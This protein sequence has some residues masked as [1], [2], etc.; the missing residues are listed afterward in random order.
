M[1]RLAV[2]LCLLALVSGSI[3]T[4]AFAIVD[5]GD[6]KVTRL[7]RTTETGGRFTCSA[8][9]IREAREGVAWILTAGHCAGAQYV[10]REVNGGISAAIDWRVVVTSHNYAGRLLDIALATAPDTRADQKYHSL[11]AEKFPDSGLVYIH[12][13][14]MGI[15]RV[16]VARVVGPTKAPNLL[17][18]MEVKVVPGSVLPGSSGSVVLDPQGFVVGVLWGMSVKP[19]DE[20]TGLVPGNVAYVTPIEAFHDLVKLIDAKL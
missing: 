9:Y 14:P 12:G 18:T 10:K 20:G 11:I 2:F 19:N 4:P 17:G 3:I 16:V 15:E 1:K 5:L 13:F 6:P 8:T 7:W